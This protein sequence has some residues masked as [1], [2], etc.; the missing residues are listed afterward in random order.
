MQN[1]RRLAELESSF[2]PCFACGQQPVIETEILGGKQWY[3]A[4]YPSEEPGSMVDEAD[5]LPLLR[6]I[7]W[8][9]NRP[10]DQLLI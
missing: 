10:D 4:R 1:P 2:A 7:W 5:D 3:R 9:N 6:L 8:V